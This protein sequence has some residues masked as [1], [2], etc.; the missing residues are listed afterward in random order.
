MGPSGSA[1]RAAASQP[2]PQFAMVEITDPILAEMA[3]WPA[4]SLY[5]RFGDYHGPSVQR[6]GVGD[7]IQ[8]TIWEAAAGGLFS[9]P[10]VLPDSTGSRSAVI[11]P[12]VVQ[13]DGSISVPYAGRIDVANRTP[14]EVEAEIVQ[15]LQGKAIQ[16][17]ALVTVAANVANTATVTGEVV[18][19]ARVPLSTRGDRIMDVIADAGGVKSP[20]HDVFINLER[21]GRS[22]RIAMERLVQD[23]HENIYVRSGDLITVVD[24]PQTFTAIGATGANAVVPFDAVGITLDE[25]IAR[26]G[27]LIDVQA[28]PRNVFVLRYEPVDHMRDIPGVAPN[29]LGS[30]FVPV[31]YHIDMRQPSALFAARLFPIRNKDIIYVSD[32]PVTDLQKIATLLGSVTSPVINAAET[33]AYIVAR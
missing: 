24:D 30:D 9:S 13:N 6:I 18:R 33:R 19:G 29:L 2:A 1:M 8:V 26:V 3:R 4:H 23:P 25:A 21:G 11:P 15:R 10:S 5:E 31:A 16:P 20:V 7:L 14:P 12:Q 17:Q 27:G 32:S 22:E 28:D